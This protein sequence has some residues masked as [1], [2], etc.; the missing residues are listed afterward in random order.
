VN[1]H[2]LSL[3]AIGEGAVAAEFRVDGR[4]MPV[5]TT[6]TVSD[7]EIATASASPDVLQGFRGTAE[8]LRRIIATV[9]AFSR[10]AR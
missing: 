4:P 7:G 6:F 1:M 5:A 8:E 2:L 3:R 10:A 9:L